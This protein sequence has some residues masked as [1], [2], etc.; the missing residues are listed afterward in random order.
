MKKYVV[1]ALFLY[2]Q[3]SLSQTKVE[4][5]Y[6]RVNC[7]SPPEI[8]SPS[9]LLQDSF[10]QKANRL[11]GEQPHNILPLP[12]ALG[13]INMPYLRPLVSPAILLGFG[14]LYL[15]NPEFLESN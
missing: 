8:A 3:V 11:L 12:P 15:G 6:S 5:L 13:A 9:N 14:F 2:S 10:M 4:S 7:F 1:L